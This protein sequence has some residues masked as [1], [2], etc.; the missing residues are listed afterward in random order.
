MVNQNVFLNIFDFENLLFILKEGCFYQK[1]IYIYSM[2]KF[3]IKRKKIINEFD[4]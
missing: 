2:T 4:S 3:F 1:Y